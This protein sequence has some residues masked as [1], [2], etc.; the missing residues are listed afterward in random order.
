MATA[1]FCEMYAWSNVLRIHLIGGPRKALLCWSCYIKNGHQ[2]VDGN[3]FCLVSLY[4]WCWH[5][6]HHDNKQGLRWGW[7]NLAESCVIGKFRAKWNPQM[8]SVLEQDPRTFCITVLGGQ[9]LI[10][11]ETPTLVL[12]YWSTTNWWRVRREQ[13]AGHHLHRGSLYVP[14][15]SRNRG[16][17]GGGKSI[18]IFLLIENF[19]QEVMT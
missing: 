18:F 9:K 7:E 6:I 5:L 14:S 15:N 1:V 16:N 12:T 3:L 8:Q 13:P 11:N 10:G 17:P 19:F 2:S 4:R